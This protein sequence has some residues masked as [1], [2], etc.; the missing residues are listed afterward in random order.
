MIWFLVQSPQKCAEHLIGAT[1]QFLLTVKEKVAA[2]S[3]EDFEAEKS[4]IRT[5]I[6]EKDPN[7]TREAQRFMVSEVS[8]HRYKFDRQ[9]RELELLETITK[10]E[11]KGYFT[12]VFFS[13]ESARLDLMITAQ[14]HKDLQAE[15]E[16]ENAKDEIYA[17]LPR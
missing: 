4:A 7:M 9:Q 10:D 8:T 2:L 5:I 14:N 1:N 17:A 13:A 12:K 16:A 11:F 15:V 3:D 6:A